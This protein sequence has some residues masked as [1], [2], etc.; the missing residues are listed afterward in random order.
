MG[1]PM[2]APTYEALA[3]QLSKGLDLC[4]RARGLEAQD[5]TNAMVE[6]FPGIDM[7]RCAPR[8][9]ARERAREQPYLTQSA[10]IPIWVQEQYDRDLLAWEDDTRSMLS[11]LSLYRPEALQQQPGGEG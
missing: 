2:V 3:A 6:A 5:R 4:I 11:R 10:T 8:L 7:E 9:N 1:E